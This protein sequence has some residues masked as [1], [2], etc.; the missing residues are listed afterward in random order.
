MKKLVAT[1]LFLYAHLCNCQHLVQSIY[2]IGDAGLP[3]PENIAYQELVSSKLDS[4]ATNTFL[5]LGDN[6]YPSGLP[7]RDDP[8]RKVS[9][10]ILNAQINLVEQYHG[11]GYFVPGNHDWKRGRKIGWRYLQNQQHYIDSAKYD[12]IELLPRSGC[13][14]PEVVMLGSSIAVII[15]DSQWFLQKRGKPIGKTSTCKC[16]SKEEFEEA[17]R[18]MLEENKDNTIIVAAH[19]PILTYG[20][21]G[22]VY[23][24]MSHIFPLV[25]VQR[26]LYIPLPVV[27]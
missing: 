25:D 8:S 22:G 6:I 11:S 4:S 13:P 18:K 3:N 9:E 1:T 20:E 7:D 21:H 10:E 5:F 23:P 15:V 26:W 16:K 24:F 27:G 17:F 19:H 12:S 14:G 2:L